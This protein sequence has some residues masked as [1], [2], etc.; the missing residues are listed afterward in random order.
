MDTMLKAISGGAAGSW[1]MANMAPRIIQGDY[2]PG[3]YIKHFIKDME[4]ANEESQAVN[5]DLCIL[6]DVLKLYK[7]LDQNNM[8]DLGTQ[9]L[10][11]YYDKQI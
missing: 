5:L 1:Q 10:I 11:K 3:F 7:D 4:I 9:A 8:G 2:K 6:K